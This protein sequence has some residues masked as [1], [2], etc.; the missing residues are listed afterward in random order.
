MIIAMG[1][2][3]LFVEY[4]SIKRETISHNKIQENLNLNEVDKNIMYF[5]RD[6]GKMI[7]NTETFFDTGKWDLKVMVKLWQ[8]N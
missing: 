3:S 7:L 4:I 8:S 1:L 6:E 2:S 5:D